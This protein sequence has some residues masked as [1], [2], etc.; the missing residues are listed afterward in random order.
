[1]DERKRESM[2]AYLR[3]RMV[4]FG[5]ESD[6]VANSIAQDEQRQN[7]D[8]YHNADGQTWDGRGEVPQWLTQ[9]TS[10]GQSPEHFA[11]GDVAR[12]VHGR[13]APEDRREDPFA[14]TRLATSH[15]SRGRSAD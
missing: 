12:S 6:D 11:A 10:A 1:M 14:G 15:G 13:R 4:E 7:A 2:V 5:I 3:R 8:R 9:A